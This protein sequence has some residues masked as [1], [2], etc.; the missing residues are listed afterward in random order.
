M[1]AFVEMVEWEYAFLRCPG[2]VS[3]GHMLHA[4]PST[5]LLRL[6]TFQRILRSDISLTREAVAFRPQLELRSANTSA[7]AHSMLDPRW[8]FET[9]LRLASCLHARL[10]KC[11]YEVDAWLWTVWT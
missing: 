5:D 3:G 8:E 6:Q 2:N 7:P 4:V 10:A 1:F 9:K 11:S